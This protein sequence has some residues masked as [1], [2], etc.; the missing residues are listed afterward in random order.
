MSAGYDAA[1]GCQQ[2]E[3]E[4][5]PA[6]YGHLTHMLKSLAGGKLVVVLEVF[7][8]FNKSIWRISNEICLLFTDSIIP[9]TQ[10]GYCMKSLA[11]NAMHTLRALL[12][13]PL[14]PLVPLRKPDAEYFSFNY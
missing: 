4:V 1:I 9:R 3:M 12:D 8:I 13:E 10:G 6:C 2:G 5:T 11:E 14:P 7:P